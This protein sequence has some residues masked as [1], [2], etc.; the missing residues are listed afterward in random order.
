MG[1]SIEVDTGALKKKIFSHI[2]QKME[3]S[4]TRRKKRRCYTFGTFSASS[5]VTQHELDYERE[6]MVED[7]IVKHDAE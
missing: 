5:V 6:L 4:D 3:P 7:I 2:L 1:R